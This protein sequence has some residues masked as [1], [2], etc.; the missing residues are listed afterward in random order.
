L[1]I[2]NKLCLQIDASKIKCLEKVTRLKLLEELLSQ[3]E[4]MAQINSSK[5][6]QSCFNCLSQA[7]VTLTCWFGTNFFN[8]DTLIGQKIAT[9]TFF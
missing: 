2:L 9:F 1:L 6:I 8:S 3:V 4:N 5:S 7:K